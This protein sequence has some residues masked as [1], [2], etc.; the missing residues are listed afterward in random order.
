M[1]AGS[2]WSMGFHSGRQASGFPILPGL[3]RERRMGSPRGQE[4]VRKRKVVLSD[5]KTTY[6]PSKGVF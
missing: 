6:V 5:Q 1:M 4:C 2:I 3:P